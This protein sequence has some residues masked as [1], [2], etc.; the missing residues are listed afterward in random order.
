MLRKVIGKA[1]NVII[2]ESYKTLSMLS[3]KQGEIISM[4]LSAVVSYWLLTLG[5]QSYSC[6]LRNKSHVFNGTFF[7]KGMHR[8]AAQ[9]LL[10]QQKKKKLKLQ[11]YLKENQAFLGSHTS[12]SQEEHLNKRKT[13][14]ALATSQ[15]R[16]RH[17]EL[18][19]PLLPNA[20]RLQG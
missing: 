8:M 3:R 18:A 15:K 16:S 1:Y 7:Q 17:R 20:E 2:S 4:K 19:S 10:Q 12:I 14:L 5:M 9:E 6:L 11:N 13:I